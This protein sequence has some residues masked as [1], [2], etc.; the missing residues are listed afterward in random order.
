MVDGKLNM[1][2]Q[3][4]LTAQT[5]NLVCIQSSVG[6]KAG[7]SV[8]CSG[9]TPPAVL[10]A[11]QTSPEYEGHGTEEGHKVGKRA[12]ALPLQ[13]QAEELYLVQLREE[14][15]AWRPN[16]NIPESKGDQPQSQRGS[17]H[18]EL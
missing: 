3:C 2:W 16:S 4:A 7:G 5:A 10:G 12:G 11:V 6:N 15:V 1:T 17:L 18:Q 9:E 14:K 13:G 8:L